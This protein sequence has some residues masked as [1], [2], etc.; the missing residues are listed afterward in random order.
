M[1]LMLS[2]LREPTRISEQQLQ[3]EEGEDEQSLQSVPSIAT[4][5]RIRS[6][7]ASSSG[8]IDIGQMQNKMAA[9]AAQVQTPMTDMADASQ[10]IQERDRII[11]EHRL[12]IEEMHGVVRQ[13]QETVQQQSSDLRDCQQEVVATG[14]RTTS[15]E[16]KQIASHGKVAAMEHRL[17]AIEKSLSVKDNALAEHDVRLLSLEMTS[18]DGVLRWKITEF[19][20]RRSEAIAGRRL[21]IYSPP[22]F[23]SRNGYKM[24]A[25]IYL[26]GDG[27]GK[28]SHLS[29]FFVIMKGDFDA[30]LPWPFQQRVT[31]TL[32][33]QEHRRHVSDTFQPDP[34][35]SSFQR[36]A[37]DMNVASGCPLFVPLEALETRGY[38][39]DDTMFVRVAVDIKGLVHP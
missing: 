12:Q 33:D 38:V 8:E 29:L 9:L 39:K 36:P 6:V 23:T 20:R 7:T 19:T 18:Y 3:E 11:E 1:G 21:S 15:F 34:V 25:R 31:F 2:Q 26:N 30:L 24:C 5:V 32:I 35:S 16:Q 27:M 28:G 14:S 22:F 17:V 10:Q 13:L 4:S 37:T